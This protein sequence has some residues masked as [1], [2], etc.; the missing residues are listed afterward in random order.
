MAADTL[1]AQEH[2]TTLLLAENDTN[3]DVSAE[4][5]YEGVKSTGEDQDVQE[6]IEQRAQW[7]W[8]WQEPTEE[9]ERQRIIRQESEW[10]INWKEPKSDE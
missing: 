8:G 9:Q 2:V 5:E 1:H 3:A 4:D 6:I 10:M 7:M